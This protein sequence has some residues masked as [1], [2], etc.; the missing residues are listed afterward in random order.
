LLGLVLLQD[1]ILLLWW[2][3]GDLA[4]DQLK[5][6]SAAKAGMPVLATTKP[7]M[8]SHPA[9]GHANTKPSQMAGLR[10]PAL[11]VRL[12]AMPR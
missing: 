7:F 5:A 9:I 6:N 1:L 2:P 10:L 11:C 12:A 8:G 3:A 4:R